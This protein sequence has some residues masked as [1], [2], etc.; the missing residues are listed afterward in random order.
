VAALV[1]LAVGIGVAA[2][3]AG[4]GQVH[5][6]RKAKG[7]GSGSTSTAQTTTTQTT[8]SVPTVDG[9]AL[10]RDGFARMQAGDFTGALQLLRRSVLALKGS[11]TFDEAYADFN[12]AYTRFA[13]GR[14]D[15]VMGLL[16][17]S[18]R[19]QGHRS[20]ID[21]LRRQWEQRC[22]SGDQSDEQAAPGDGRGKDKGKGKGHGSDG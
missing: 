20:Q 19:I 13:L 1:L 5:A 6:E 2:F 9:V 10:N 14:C 4:D 11:N 21:D 16:L 3:A 22:G 8:E 7:S 18:E 12:L 15:G 17:R